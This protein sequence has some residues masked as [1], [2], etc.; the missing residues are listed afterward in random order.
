MRI[1]KSIKEMQDI[2]KRVRKK[3]MTIGFVPTMGS[4]HEGHLSLVREARRTSDFL[5]VSIF[6]NPIQFGPH[7]DMKKYPRDMKR[8]VLLLSRCGVDVIFYPSASSIYPKG[9]KTYVEVIELQGKMCGASRP[10][11]F[12]GVATVVTKLF[13]IVKPDNAFFG[14][15][16]YQQQII[17]KAMAKD[18]NMDINVVSMPT[19]REKN[20]LAMSSRNI[21]LDVAERRQAG[22]LY[23]ALQLAKTLVKN[24]NRNPAKIKTA[25]KKLIRESA[26]IRIDYVSICDPETL[27]EVKRI[28][29]KILVAIAAYVGKARLIDNMIVYPGKYK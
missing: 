8:D 28:A 10:G 3:G 21:Y 26:S 17:I 19:M 27:E 25:M 23:K 6:V 24:G 29:G 11:H 7:E 4:L 22:M 15:K 1:I 5:V 20:G 18:L 2:S 9:Y 14:E 12:K 13:N 16:D